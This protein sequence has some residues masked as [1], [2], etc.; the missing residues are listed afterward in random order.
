MVDLIRIA[1]RE[2]RRP[3]AVGYI[4]VSSEEQTRG[5]SLDGQR[6]QIKKRCE[7]EGWDLVHIYADRGHS[8]WQQKSAKRPEFQKML[9]D[10]ENGEFDV[11]VVYSADRLGRNVLDSIKTLTTFMHLGTRLLSITEGPMTLD[12]EGKLPAFLTLLLA[13]I[14]SDKT[15]A[16]V[17]NGI[18]ARRSKGRQWG[19]LPYGYQRC[20]VRCLDSDDSH[21]YCHHHP[22]K[23]GFVVEAYEM[24]ASGLHS[25]AQIASW[26]NQNG[27][28]TN[29]HK[30]DRPGLVLNELPFTHSA[31]SHILKNSFYAGYIKDSEAESGIRPGVHRPIVTE[32]LFEKVQSRFRDNR[33]KAG[34]KSKTPR[35]LS[36]MVR[37][38]RCNGRYNL[39]RQG[40]SRSLFLRMNRSE[41]SDCSCR[42]RSFTSRHLEEQVNRLFNHFELRQDWQNFVVDHFIT[43]YDRDEVGRE[44]AWLEERRRRVNN[45]YLDQ[46][47]SE[48]EYQTQIRTIRS[49]LE[50]LRLPED[51]ESVMQ[52]GDYLAK[53]PKVWQRAD[54]TEKNVMLHHMLEAIY[55][56]FETKRLHSIAPTASFI[57]PLRAMIERS[58]LVLEEAP[59][60][61]DSR[62]FEDAAGCTLI[63]PTTLKVTFLEQRNLVPLETLPQRMAYRRAELGIS[64]REMAEILEISIHSVVAWGRGRKPGSEMHQLISNWLAEELAHPPLWPWDSVV[65]GQRIRDHRT[66]WG[67]SLADLA[68]ILGTFPS[69]LSSWERGLTPS[70][71]Y[72]RRILAWLEKDAP[73]SDI[74]TW[75]GEKMSQRILGKRLALRLTQRELADQFSVGTGVLEHWE[76]GQRP[77]KQNRRMLL[78]WLGNDDFYMDIDHWDST[79]MGQR[80]REKR[81]ALG[82]SSMDIATYFSTSRATLESW[83]SGKIP[84]RHNRKM[85]LDWLGD[86]VFYM[87]ID[88]WTGAGM[89]RLIRDRR[90][91]WGMSL[92]DLGEHL[93]VHA[94]TVGYWEVDLSIPH[95]AARIRILNWL[96]EEVTCPAV[97]PWD[98]EEMGKRIRDRR[99]ALEMSQPQLAEQFGVSTG[100]V[101]SWERGRTPSHTQRMLVSAWLAEEVP[102]RMPRQAQTK[103]LVQRMMDRRQALRISRRKMARSM[104]VSQTDVHYWEQGRTLPNEENRRKIVG[105]LDR[106]DF[107]PVA[108]LLPGMAEF[109]KAA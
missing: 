29:G 58:D 48:D 77:S 41:W 68:E 62:E 17:T 98:G 70:V 97:W 102:V 9:R 23:A 95:P 61:T 87:D 2:G 33:A 36:K 35:M 27:C 28:R 26:L 20:D 109:L 108:Q 73:H 107:D 76:G 59:S 10:A 63:F 16:H 37:C 71:K 54:K 83:E 74:V 101:G 3:R 24:Y 40:S 32:E 103:A 14:Q 42:G 22:D 100:T 105:W 79:V 45:M 15:S 91:E 34:R 51:R 86:N 60:F 78:D 93:G 84:S 49:G 6:D 92:E 57:G 4:R 94:E 18:R 1:E 89:G 104:G 39:T 50:S 66:A 21:P 8:A 52:A 31:V 30:A 96:N 75:N 99:L 11:V 44:Q 7:Q 25:M 46:E 106:T 13:E 12:G 55:A 53:F 67:H 47:I 82:L 19:A 43:G 56:D 72:R 80:I 38:Y 69:Q 81:L 85:L 90:L 88:A 5:H 64:Q 65:M